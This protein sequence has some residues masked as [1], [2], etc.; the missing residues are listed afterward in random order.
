MV[1]KDIQIQNTSVNS[2]HAQC[3]NTTCQNKTVHDILVVFIMA[4]YKH[5]HKNSVCISCIVLSTNGDLI[6]KSTPGTPAETLV[7]CSIN[8]CR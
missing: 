8:S 1:K 3:F 7:Q 5:V 2:A 6:L 4:V